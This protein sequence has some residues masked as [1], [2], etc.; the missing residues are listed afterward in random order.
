MK[1]LL[2]LSL[3]LSMIGVLI[4]VS[5]VLRIHRVRKMLMDTKEDNSVDK[6]PSEKIPSKMSVEDQLPNLLDGE[7]KRVMHSAIG[8]ILLNK[9]SVLGDYTRGQIT[10]E[11][12]NS[13]TKYVVRFPRIELSIES[14]KCMYEGDTSYHLVASALGYDNKWY[15]FLTDDLVGSEYW[16]KELIEKDKLL[17][18]LYLYCKELYDY[19]V[20]LYDYVSVTAEFFQRISNITK[21]SNRELYVLDHDQTN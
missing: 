14:I 6:T 10:K 18:R 21:L 16:S 20:V 4:L 11:K 8:R 5:A 17:Q 15:H 19:S 2:I 1:V 3:V 9:G 12:G 7:F 13:I